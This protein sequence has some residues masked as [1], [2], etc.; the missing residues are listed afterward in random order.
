MFRVF[1]CVWGQH[2][3]LIVGLAAMILIVGNLA[4]FLALQRAQECSADRRSIWLAIGAVSGGF[5]VWATHFVAM[6]AYDGGL[7]IGFA[8]LPT[9]GSAA[10]AVGGF[11]IALTILDRQTTAQCIAAGV[12]TAL[13]VG[14]M[15][16]CGMLAIRAQA[17][18]VFD[19]TAVAIGAA[20]AIMLFSAAL[21]AFG[22]LSGLR[23]VVVASL[24][25][26]SAVCA[27][28][29]TSMSATTLH[30]DPT[31][32]VVE[33]GTGREWLIG[34]VVGST[35]VVIILTAVST[36][37]DRYLTDL[38]G[39]AGATLEGIAIVRDHRIV[40]ANPRFAGM[41]GQSQT[42]LVGQNIETLMAAADG[43]RWPRCA[44]SRSRQRRAAKKA[45][46]C[47]KSQCMNS[48]IAGEPRKCWPFGI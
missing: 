13:T 12:A 6:L 42:D 27:L 39:F 36:L 2:D 32:P 14:A 30:F 19:W 44:K 24:A 35:I 46:R 47:S 45:I 18:I 10:I 8:F 33:V 48:N 1:E 3:H 20:I 37:I 41:V 5:G 17:R 9:L 16:F 26:V 7:P 23:Q 43:A 29:F 38:K 25:S 34:S 15:H 22:R 40:E 21:Y 31:L 11:W 4:F 28:H